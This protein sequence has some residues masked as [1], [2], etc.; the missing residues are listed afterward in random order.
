[1]QLVSLF[2]QV[3]NCDS[4]IHSLC[5]KSNKASHLTVG[6]PQAAYLI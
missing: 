5:I 2:I 4:N 1:M 3:C 6:Y